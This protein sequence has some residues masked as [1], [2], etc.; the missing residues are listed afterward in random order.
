MSTRKNWEEAKEKMTKQK[1]DITWLCKQKLG[2]KLD[3]WWKAY[4]KYSEIK[5]GG[6]GSEKKLE[7]MAACIAPGD[8]AVQ[9]MKSYTYK[10]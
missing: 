8:K 6:P 5:V 2:E 4:Y 3:A 1:L 9:V 10:P 7:A